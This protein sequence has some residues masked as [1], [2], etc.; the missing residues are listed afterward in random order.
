MQYWWM[1]LLMFMF[2]YVTCK[3]FYF[4][5]SARLGLNLVRASHII[6]LSAVIKAME[7]L[8]QARGIMLQHMLQ[9]EKESIQIS[10]FELRFNE[11]MKTL[12]DRSVEILMAL[13]PEFFKPTMEF[14]DWASAMNYLQ[15]HKEAALA[16]WDGRSDK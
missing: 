14:E 2:G 10:S 7:H 12:Q 5:R 6:Y 4:F 16:F 8:F 9:T 11:E 3:T 15:Q 1:F 13:H